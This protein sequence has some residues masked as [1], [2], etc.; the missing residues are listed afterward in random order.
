MVCRT[1][2]YANGGQVKCMADGG[3][4]KKN[5]LPPPKKG[6]KPK[7]ITTPNK[8]GHTGPLGANAARDRKKG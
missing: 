6:P 4:V 8:P 3:M 5:P 7:K 2:K 1:H